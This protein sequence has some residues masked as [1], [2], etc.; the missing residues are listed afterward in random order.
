[1]N[2]RALSALLTV[3]CAGVS[4]CDPDA[5][6]SADATPLAFTTVQEDLFSAPGAQPNAWVDFDGDGDL[7][8][9]VG[10]RGAPNR[11]YRNDNAVFTDIASEVG[12]ADTIDTRVAAWGDYDADGDLDVYVGYPAGAA[13]PNRLYRNEGGGRSFVDVAAELGVDL[14]GTTRQT[15]WIDYDADGDVDLFIAFRDGPNRLFRNDGGAF[16]DVTGESGIGDPRRTVG[17]A[18][19]DMD[20]DGDLDA[21]VANQNGDAD[22]FFR[23][24]GGVFTDV[25]AELGMDGGARTEEYGGVGPDVADYDN[26]G[27]LDLFVANY[28]P[29]ALWRNEGGGRFTEVAAGT[30][31]GADLH[32]TTA[33]WGDV[34]ND[35]W[36]DIYVAAYLGND[37][38]APDHLFLNRA[39]TLEDATPAAFLNRGASHGVRWADY[40]GDGDLDLALANNNLSSGHWL[41]RNDLPAASAARSIQVRVLD[42]SGLHTRAGAEVRVFEAGTDRL[43]GTR[44]VDSGGG[45]CSQGSAPVHVGLPPG[46]TTVDVEVTVLTGAGRRAVRVDGVDPDTLPG[47]VLEVRA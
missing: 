40:D 15:S 24:D 2:V 7:D 45:Y 20:A 26:D 18:W 43:L 13:T 3:V 12:L 28:G 31:V 29:D 36:V 35:G 27:D 30:V 41:Y 19:F 4:A 38:E 8:L 9:F 11:L 39:G 21:F 5:E 32:S 1:M 42:E 10:F 47:R 22:A 16:V 37:P 34:D 25:A 33:A 44:L 23:N 14:I 17:V 6:P 46:T